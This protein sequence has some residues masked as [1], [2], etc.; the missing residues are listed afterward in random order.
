MTRGILFHKGQPCPTSSGN[1]LNVMRWDDTAW[2]HMCCACDTT[3]STC[4]LACCTC[5]LTCGLACCTC[6]LTCSL[7]C[8]TCDLTCGLAC[9][10]CDLTCGLACCT[11]G[12]ACC[13]CSLTCCTCGLT[14]FTCQSANKKHILLNCFA[15]IHHVDCS[16]PSRHVQH[17]SLQT[18]LDLKLH[19]WHM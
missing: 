5:D 7:A 16:C 12:L 14:C 11:C 17:F 3:F 1:W 9:C 18:S 19:I 8:C 10:T 2:P 4:G 15:N 6:D 13:T